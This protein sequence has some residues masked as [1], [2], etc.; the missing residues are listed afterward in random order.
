MNVDLSIFRMAS[1]ET[2][3][4]AVAQ[5]LV[6]KKRQELELRIARQQVGKSEGTKGGTVDTALQQMQQQGELSQPATP[7]L[8][9]IVVDKT[10]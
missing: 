6:A 10:A 8:R 3:S 7:D 1:R 5:V 9:G 2:E 4:L